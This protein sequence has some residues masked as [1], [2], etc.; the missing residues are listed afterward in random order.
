MGAS[1]G[2]NVKIYVTHVSYLDVFPVSK[3]LA[4]V[5]KLL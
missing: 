5:G 1:R 3:P 4:T 2:Q